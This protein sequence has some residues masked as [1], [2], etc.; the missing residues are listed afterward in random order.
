MKCTIERRTF[1]D[2]SIHDYGKLLCEDQ[3]YN[4]SYEYVKIFS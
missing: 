2:T 1:K 4:P 3:I